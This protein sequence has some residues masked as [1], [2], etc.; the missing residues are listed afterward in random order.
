MRGGGAGRA[1]RW[2]NTMLRNAGT[3]RKIAWEIESAANGAFSA[4]KEDRA[5]EEPAITNQI[6]GAIVDRIRNLTYGNI[7]WRARP[8][9]TG[10]GKAAEEKR[11]GADLLGVLDISIP[12]YT[13][14][15]G[16]LAQ[17][18]KAEPGMRFP[19]REWGRLCSQCELMLA[20]TPDS[21]VF[22]YSIN[23]GLRIF[24]ANA[25]LGLKSRDIFQLYD[26]RVA[27]FFEHHIQCF[28]GDPRLNST[29]IHTLDVLA[30][31][32]VENIL[33]LSARWA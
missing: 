28:I 9:R 27:T 4:Y 5:L 26:R 31:L 30:E 2:R 15:K 22:I 29:N 21:F 14:K 23:K 18:K 24:P 19:S 13:T 7:S 33:E 1:T 20:R 10:P 17:A 16:F 12:G 11:H 3:V 32:P 6:I 25:V 8:L